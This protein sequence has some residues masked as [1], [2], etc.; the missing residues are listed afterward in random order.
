MEERQHYF[1]NSLHAHRGMFSLLAKEGDTYGALTFAERMKGRVLL[2]VLQAGRVS[3]Q[4]AMTRDE[5]EEERRLN[6]RLASLN[7]QMAHI[8]Q[9]DKPDARRLGEVKAQLDK[10]RLDYEAFE[11]ALYATHPELQIQRG[12]A[13]VVTP[14]ELASLLPD[15]SSA[16]LEY[17]VGD[18]HS[19]L[20][21][22]TKARNSAGLETHL[23][24]LTVRR[25][26]LAKQ[27]E[28]FRGELAGRDLGFRASAQKL[29]ELLLKPARLQLRG[30]TNLIIVPDDRLWD[31]PFQALA[32]PANRFLIEDCAISYAPSLT[33]L[34][35]MRKSGRQ[36][37]PD[38]EE[39]LL[40]LGNPTGVRN[41]P[42]R[43][44]PSRSR[45]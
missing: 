12:Q 18:E 10:A 38:K 1:E 20:F 31:L 4:R 2:D 13:P 27:I 24:E 33:V 14:D 9:G 34:R 17:V 25:A 44:C 5:S 37:E 16:L 42:P 3:I 28:A 41:D 19:Y 7:R 45:R 6:S 8:G 30:R 26:D 39:T 36:R 35:E 21:V 11:T 22:I 40:A 15:S 32:T 29:G 43:P 23:Y